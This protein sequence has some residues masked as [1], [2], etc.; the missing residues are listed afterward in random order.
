MSVYISLRF[1]FEVSLAI[2]VPE[3]VLSDFFVFLSL[4]FPTIDIHGMS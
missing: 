3:V 2:Q 1:V 4:I